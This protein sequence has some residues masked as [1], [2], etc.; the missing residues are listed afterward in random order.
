M[1]TVYRARDLIDGQTVAVKLLNVR[2]GRGAERF[3][4]EAA[5][6]ADL[7]H[8]VIVRYLVHGVTEAGERYLAME[9]LEGEDLGAR[10]G[11][12]DQD[13]LSLPDSLFIIRRAAEAQSKEGD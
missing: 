9:W 12:L 1:G 5:I 7:M 2:D 13:P 10:L 4:M 11:R 8:P 6:L 3:D